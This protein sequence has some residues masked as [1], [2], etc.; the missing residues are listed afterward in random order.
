MRCASI[1]ASIGMPVPMNAV[2][3]SSISRAA[4]QMSN[5]VGL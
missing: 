5:S 2:A 4:E 3:P 1:A